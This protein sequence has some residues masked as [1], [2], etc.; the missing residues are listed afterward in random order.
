M[1][2]PAQTGFWWAAG[3]RSAFPNRRR[4][5]GLGSFGVF[6]EPRPAAEGDIAAKFLAAVLALPKVNNLFLSSDHFSVNRKLIEA[7]AS[8]KSIKPKAQCRSGLPW[9]ETL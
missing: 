1:V 7:W 3:I 5:R 9:S 8:M 2:R 6:E 4:R